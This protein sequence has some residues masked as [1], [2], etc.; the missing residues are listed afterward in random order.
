VRHDAIADTA[1]IEIALASFAAGDYVVEVTNDAD[2]N[3]DPRLFAFRVV[4]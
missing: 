2:A 3:A 4:P 1:A